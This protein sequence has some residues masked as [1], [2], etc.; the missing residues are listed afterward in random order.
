ML[1]VIGKQLYKK[2]KFETLYA[3]KLYYVVSKIQRKQNTEK[4]NGIMTGKVPS[5]NYSIFL[6]K[7]DFK[8]R[9]ATFPCVVC[10]EFKGISVS[11]LQLRTR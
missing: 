6:T 11:G 5:V 2:T 9:K 10:S 3:I 7:I 1:A 4:A 8:Q